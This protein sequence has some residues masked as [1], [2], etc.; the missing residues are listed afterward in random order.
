MAEQNA[1]ME[2]FEEIS[3]FGQPALFTNA[4]I[5]RNSVPRGYYAYD[6]R[7]DDDGQGNAVQI[8][9]HILV[10]HLGAVITRD[11]VKLSP[12]GF[13]D[14]KPDDIN[15]YGIGECGSMKSFMETYP[16]KVRPQVS[17]ER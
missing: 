17:R 6:I 4:R 11:E 8:A 7:H 13:L 16:P 2:D 10:N 5:D 9:R 12:D 15:Y 3:L 1:M 14:M